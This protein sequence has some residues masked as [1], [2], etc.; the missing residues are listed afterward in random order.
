LR[1][2]AQTFQAVF[3]CARA[4]AQGECNHASILSTFYAKL[5]RMQVPKC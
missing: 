2:N 4:H 1:S 5:L 3:T